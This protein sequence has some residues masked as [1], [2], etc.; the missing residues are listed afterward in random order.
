M[1][2]CHSTR[3]PTGLRAATLAHGCAWLV[4]LMLCG[5]GHRGPERVT[6]SG[7]VTYRGQP[8]SYGQIHFV[9]AENTAGVPVTAATI[10][11]GRYTASIK[12]G[13]FVGSHEVRIVAYRDSAPQGVPVDADFVQQVQYL[14]EK[15]NS[16]SELRIAIPSGSS[17]IHQDFD[18]DD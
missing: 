1:Y 10:R 7:Q 13:V 8:L 11:D 5:C 18:L 6:V 2:N 9:P 3:R 17:A 12:G 16:Q 4:L 15:Y 14:P